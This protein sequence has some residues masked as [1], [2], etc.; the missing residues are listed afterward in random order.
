EVVPALAREIGAGAVFWNRRYGGPERT[1]DAAI[2]EELRADGVEV[3]SFAGSLLYEPWTV[4][5]GAGTPYGVFTP[6]WNACRQLP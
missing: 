4:R 5:T 3:A 6:F 1:V 2:K